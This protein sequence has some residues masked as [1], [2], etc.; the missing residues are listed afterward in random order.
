MAL[1]NPYQQYQQQSVMTAT[2]GELTL[3]LYNGCI[4]FLKQ[5]EQAIDQKNVQDANTNIIKAQKILT[6]LMSTLDM[7][8]DISKGLMPIYRFMYEQL[9]QANIKKDT[10][11]INDVVDLVTGFRDTWAQA[12]KEAKK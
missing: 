12:V 4:R 1:L 8:Y 9:V 11:I 3:M 6:E 7:D 2:P 10:K 5:A